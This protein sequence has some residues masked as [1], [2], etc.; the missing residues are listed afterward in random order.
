MNPGGGTEVGSVWYDAEFNTAHLRSS[1]KEVESIVAQ[2]D[3]KMSSNMRGSRASIDSLAD[4]L[5]QIVRPAVVGTAA[6]A[7]GFGFATMAAFN[8]VKAV[9]EASFAL[10]AYE[11][12]GDAVNKVL[13][14][15]L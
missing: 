10:R 3:R 12:D 14:Q 11:K 7:T 13:G 9:E 8:Q 2:T 15:L 1:G 5:G 4:S 6:V